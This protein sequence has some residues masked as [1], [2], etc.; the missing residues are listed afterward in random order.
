M[1]IQKFCD[2]TSGC[3]EPFIQTLKESCPSRF[4]ALSNEE[5]KKIRKRF[6]KIQ[7][8]G[9]LHKHIQLLETDT[10]NNTVIDKKLTILRQLGE[11]I[12]A[13]K[14]PECSKA[15]VNILDQYRGNSVSRAVQWFLAKL[16]FFT[17][18]FTPQS[19]YIVEKLEE[20]DWVTLGG[21][22]R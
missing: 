14:K 5:A 17:S 20:S 10:T 16:F 13:G 3:I 18:W 6:Q 1:I 12:E 9:T 19:L 8:L 22:I 21:Y 15:D 7:A 11:S 2:R 4:E